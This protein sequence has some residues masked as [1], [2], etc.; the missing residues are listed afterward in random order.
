MAELHLPRKD[1]E[2]LDRQFWQSIDFE[3]E[4]FLAA[5]PGEGG[6]RVATTGSEGRKVPPPHSA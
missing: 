6:E 4:A 3:R 5:T 2:Q 1:M